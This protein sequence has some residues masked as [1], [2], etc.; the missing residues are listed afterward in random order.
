MNIEKIVLKFTKIIID[1]AKKTIGYLKSNSSKSRIPWWNNDIKQWIQF[2]NITLKTFIQTK[3]QTD[4]IK[5]KKLKAKTRFLVKRS[6]TSSWRN[7]TSNLGSQ[8]DSHIMWNKMYSLQGRKKQN[9]IHLSI[10]SFP[11]PLPTF[12]E[13]TRKTSVIN[14]YTPVFSKL[15]INLHLR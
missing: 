14:T 10:N 9:N 2:K 8:I 4:H 3:L 13:N 7:F 5:L 12:L 11:F 6:K 1:T 15:I